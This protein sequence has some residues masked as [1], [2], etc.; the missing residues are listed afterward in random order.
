[1]TPERER[2][3]NQPMICEH[4]NSPSSISFHLTAV[5]FYLPQVLCGALDFRTAAR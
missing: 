5:M 1:M 2:S 3:L 4:I